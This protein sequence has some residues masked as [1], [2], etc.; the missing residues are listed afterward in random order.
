LDEAEER[1]DGALGRFDLTHVGARQVE[2]LSGG[3][4]QRVAL[5]R[6]L[7]V[8]APVVLADEP[9]SELDEGNRDRVLEELRQEVELGRTVVVATH[10][11]AI[12]A[13]CDVHYALDEGR[14]TL[15]EENLAS[16]CAGALW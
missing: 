15:F 11:P 4:M 13:A 6:A 8:G 14:L 5:A 10:D 3:Q 16:G 2:E 12:V 1:A 7:V 9:T